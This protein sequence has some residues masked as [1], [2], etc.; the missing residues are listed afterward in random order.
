MHQHCCLACV[1]LHALTLRLRTVAWML[2]WGDVI[3][4]TVD[5]EHETLADMLLCT[6]YN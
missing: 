4:D 3:T 2:K 6:R 5:L 1:V